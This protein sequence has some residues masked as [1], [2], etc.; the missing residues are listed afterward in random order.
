MVSDPDPPH[1]PRDAPRGATSLLLVRHGES[2]ANVAARAAEAAGAEVVDVSVRDADVPLTATGVAQAEALG[3]WLASR[4]TP[5]R[6]DAVWASPYRRAADTAGIALRIFRDRADPAPG[7]EPTRGSA[8]GRP[9]HGPAAPARGERSGG[10]PLPPL[11]PLLLDERL[12]DREL[13]VLESL[14]PRGVQARQPAEAARRQRLGRFYYRPPGGESWADVALRLRSFLTV[15][16][17]DGCGANALV[18]SH[19]AVILLIRV[20]CEGLSEADALRLAAAEPLL[21]GSI[22]QLVREHPQ[23]PW[24]L[25]RYNDVS[26]L[27]PPA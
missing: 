26:H 23:A 2:T 21:N 7:T 3:R 13:G 11:P 20:V 8:P 15:L 14:T 17:A 6:P 16:D 12:R 9:Q 18:V 19:D 24:R 4:S 27:S 5:E 22:T 1:N 25:E 10:S